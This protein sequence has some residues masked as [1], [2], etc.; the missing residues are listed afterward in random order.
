MRVEASACVLK[1]EQISSSLHKSHPS[2]LGN[3][4]LP[5]MPCEGLRSQEFQRHLSCRKYTASQNHRAPERLGLEGTLGMSSFHPLPCVGMPLP[6]SGC[7]KP[8]QMCL[9]TAQ[10]VAPTLP[11]IP[12][13]KQN[14]PSL[15]Y[16]S[17]PSNL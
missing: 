16:F 5:A 11:K 6:R 2:G 3:K 9:R 8:H 17:S 12:I 13:R 4:T 1:A 7:S 10:V 15:M 14:P